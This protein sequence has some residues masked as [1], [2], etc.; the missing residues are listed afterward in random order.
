MQLVAAEPLVRDPIAMAF[1]ADGR[2]YVVEMTGYSEQRDTVPGTIR[3]LEDTDGDGVFEKAT[4]FLEGLPWAVAVACWEGGVFVGVPP[5]ILYAKDLDGDGV[6]DKKEVVFTGFALSNVQGMMNTFLWT[7]DNRIHGATSS[8]GGSVRRPDQDEA[9][10]RNLNGR[11]FSFDPRTRELR[12][13]SGGA[14]HGLS[15]DDFGN[16]FVCS[17]SDH[18]QWVWHEDR[19]AAMNPWYSPPPPRESIAV[20]GPAAEVFRISPVEP[21]RELRTRLRVKGLVPGPIEGGGR[22]AG[23]FT[24]ATGV[25]VYRGDAWP[26]SFRGQVF[27]GDVGGN[28]IHRK[29]LEYDAQRGFTGH[30]VDENREFVASTDIWF[31]PVQFANAPDG[32]LYVADMYRE[33]IEHPDSLPPIIKKHLDLTS[34]NDRGRIYRIAPKGFAPRRAPALSGLPTEE[35]VPLL[36]HDNAWHRET[37]ARLIFERQDAAAISPL[38]E[39]A[40]ASPHTLGR[41]HAL[42]ALHGLHALKP[43]LLVQAASDREA[44][45]R[46]QAARLAVEYAASE[47]L[48]AA[49]LSLAEDPDAHVRFNTAWSLG[50]FPERVRVPALASIAQRDLQNPRTMAAVLAGAGEFA[51]QLAYVLLRSNA[52]PPGEPAMA[53]MESLARIAASSKHPSATAAVLHA[54][55]QF[56]AT[57]KEKAEGLLRGLLAGG[58][59]LHA[60]GT[61]PAAPLLTQ[62]IADS[63]LQ[64]QDSSLDAAVRVRGVATLAFAPPDSDLDVL[65][66]LLSPQTPEEVQAAALDVLA[67]KQAS[68]AGRILMEAWPALGPRLRAQATEVLFRRTETLKALMESMAAGRVRPSELDATRKRVLLQHADPEIQAAA[69]QLLGDALS[70]DRAA[71]LENYRQALELP[72]DPARGAAI[73]AANCTPCHRIKDQGH[74][75]G[76]N[77]ATVAQ[78]G[79]EKILS[80][81]LHPNAE[82]NPQYVNYTVETN[83][84]EVHSGIIV[85]ESSNSITLKRAYGETEV[86]PRS[87]IDTIRSEALSIMPEGLESAIS[88]QQMADLLAYITS[89]D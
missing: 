64:A 26:A 44:A 45:V 17:N 60:D 78:A 68:E 83:D 81:I 75:V 29:K 86:I 55:E 50:A 4:P 88:V 13:E 2:C 36:A 85:A 9:A 12:A 47:S 70:S 30:R 31:R 33:V 84:F 34:G 51:G 79:P 80:N 71:V 5:D 61:S 14:Q 72:G 20:D 46:A 56:A 42:Y 48:Q 16:K 52:F 3:L 19:M 57:D 21:W 40:T 65:G 15:F 22:A 11:D 23:Y 37:A 27:I 32:C 43:E 69:R 10:A 54:I 76:P 63:R 77:L 8:S 82:L 67:G 53:C 25:T 62:L 59:S 58:L 38:E 73:F 49:M 7:L 6:A 39:L 28:L 66:K 87:S 74:D 41:I 1:D 89:S 18:L 35:L 24:S